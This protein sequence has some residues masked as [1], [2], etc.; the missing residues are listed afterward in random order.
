M[1]YPL[2]VEALDEPDWDVT[3]PAQYHDW[4][5]S[6]DQP[7]RARLH[8]LF[9]ATRTTM[10]I[11]GHVHCHRAKEVEGIRYVISPATSF[12]QWA[13]RWPDGDAS[14]GFL[15]YD[16]SAGGIRGSFVPL[17]K[18]YCLRGYGPGGHPAPHVR[19]YACAWERENVQ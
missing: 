1:H 18:Q 10:V 4:Y 6:I 11:S 9:K 14:L 19:D 17:R 15:K 16:V 8:R 2:F 12:G 3:D 13:D 7:G 5:F